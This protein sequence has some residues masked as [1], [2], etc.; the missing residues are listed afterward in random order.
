MQILLQYVLPLFLF[1]NMAWGSLCSDT[2]AHTIVSSV[3]PR[4]LV[5]DAALVHS[6]PPHDSS[7]SSLKFKAGAAHALKR[8]HKDLQAKANAVFERLDEAAL[9]NRIRNLNDWIT[10]INKDEGAPVLSYLCEAEY[11]LFVLRENPHYLVE[12]EP[13]NGFYRAMNVDIQRLGM[14]QKSIDLK[15]IDSRNAKVIALKEI[16]SSR[17]RTSIATNVQDAYEKV[18]ITHHLQV[19]E[20]MTDPLVE[21][22]IVYFYDYDSTQKALDPARI[23]RFGSLKTAVIAYLDYIQKKDALSDKPFDVFTFLDFGSRR[24]FHIQRNV[25]DSLEVYEFSLT[26]KSF[27]L[28]QPRISIVGAADLHR[29]RQEP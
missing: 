5:R 20:L 16:K 6:R 28:F 2:L 8:I 14:R 15:I 11:A 10:S 17:A 26:D 22:G 18:R 3:H 7:Y 21:I 12:F 29:Q 1:T 13:E 27:I 19:P 4:A 25:D 24:V 23:H 9:N